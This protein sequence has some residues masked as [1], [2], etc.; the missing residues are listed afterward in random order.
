GNCA[1]VDG[2]RP[3]GPVR[4]RWRTPDEVTL[5]RAGCS[6]RTGDHDRCGRGLATA[7]PPTR[8]REPIRARP[9]Q[10]CPVRSRSYCCGTLAEAVLDESARRRSALMRTAVILAAHGPAN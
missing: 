3:R 10:P 5:P 4:L 8:P 2:P 6:G 1:R 9:S 7:P